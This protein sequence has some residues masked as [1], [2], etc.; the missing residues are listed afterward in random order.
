MLLTERYV[1]A[2]VE[3]QSA[4]V[5][6]ESA[7][8]VFVP[9][10]ST[11]IVC[12]LSVL[13][14]WFKE[15]QSKI[16]PAEEITVYCY[17]GNNRNRDPAFLASHDIVLT[18]FAT[19]ACEIPPDSSKNLKRTVKVE[20]SALMKVNW[21]RVVLDE[22]HTIKDRNTRTA[23][24]AFALKAER[25][26]CVTGTPIQNKLDDIFSLLHFLHVEPYGEYTWWS[27][28]IA[29]PM[30]NK[31]DKAITRLQ[32]IL[33]GIMLRR[34]KDQKVGNGTPIVS[35]P[36]RTV[37][38]HP[39]TLSEEEDKLYQ[40]LWSSSKDQV[41]NFIE[42]GTLMENYAHVLELL[43]RLR[44]ACDHPLLIKKKTL[45]DAQKLQGTLSW[46]AQL[47]PHEDLSRLK[48]ILSTDLSDEECAICLETMDNPVATI[49]G[50][51][52]CRACIEAHLSIMQE[53]NS[54]PIC[55]RTTPMHL[56][57]PLPNSSFGPDPVEIKWKTSSK[58][59]ALLRSLSSINDVSVKSIVF[60]QWTSM[61]DLVEPALTSA[62]MRYV[63]LDGSMNYQQREKSINAFKDDPTIRVSTKK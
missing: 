17:H 27:K 37:K 53:N 49:C 41:T 29:R 2:T 10:K 45:N 61:L 36:P 25:R 57:V 9:S 39:V 4:A 59:E 3:P 44:Q 16:D 34:T 7:D 23:K 55:R 35:L 26:W 60:S 24:A 43:L 46:I 32:G 48:E 28:V 22:A 1:P 33:H 20:D 21:F 14:Q 58:I 38:L 19:L 11:L 5:D 6:T 51:V 8:E 18:T 52:F 15:I 54:C 12:P 50:H 40:T 63:R 56:L 13:H 62:G 42:S 31:D 47:A 30:K